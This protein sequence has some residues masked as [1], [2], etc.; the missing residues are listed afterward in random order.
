MK[1][2]VLLLF[3]VVSMLS[4]CGGAANAQPED[5][6]TITSEK[7]G[8]TL[9]YVSAGKFEMGSGDKYRNER[10]VHSVYLSAYYIGLYEVTNAEYALCVEAGDCEK[11]GG[12]YYSNPDY[13]DHP[14]THIDWNAAQ[15][16]CQWIGGSLPTEA[17][18]EKAA[19]GT[20]GRS[21]PWGE[22]IDPSLANYGFAS[23]QITTAVGSYRKSVV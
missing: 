19:R 16:Y 4:A 6:D 9:V 2:S 22:G 23:S 15:I 7:G 11:P 13:D 12:S 20:D 14:V 8:V 3:V 18:W 5:G 1:K 17:Q 21:Y 10:P